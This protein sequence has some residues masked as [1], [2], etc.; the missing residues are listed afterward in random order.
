MTWTVQFT[1]LAEDDVDEAYAWYA[2]S[3]RGLG[4]E[5]LADMDAQFM[6]N[7]P[8]HKLGGFAENIQGDVRAEFA[9]ALDSA[10][11]PSGTADWAKATEKATEWE[12]LLQ[13]DSDDQL[14]VMWGDAGMIYFGLRREDLTSA[15]FENSSVIL[16]CS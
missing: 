11:K 2:S 9:A 14:N 6:G 1:G 10:G 4:D 16:Q 12:L 15:R 3:R 13:I 7:Q 5:F 8:R